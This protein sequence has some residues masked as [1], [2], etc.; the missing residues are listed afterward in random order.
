MAVDKQTIAY[1]EAYIK[2]ASRNTEA[3]NKIGAMLGDPEILVLFTRLVCDALGTAKDWNQLWHI[4]QI[5]RAPFSK[6][7][8]RSGDFFEKNF[9]FNKQIRKATGEKILEFLRNDKM[10]ITEN[11][12]KV[13]YSQFH[14]ETTKTTGWWISKKEVPKTRDDIILEIQ[15]RSGA[16]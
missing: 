3:E 1:L 7:G 6:H 4:H 9:R 8:F 14:I 11:A 10:P 5:V 12:K 13:M 2:T 16:S 15:T